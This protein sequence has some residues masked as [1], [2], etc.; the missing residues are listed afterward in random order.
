MAD[1]AEPIQ[2]HVYPPLAPG[3]PHIAVVMTLDGSVFI[4]RRAL[5]EKAGWDAIKD[6]FQEVHGQLTREHIAAAIEK[7]GHT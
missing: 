6:V 7:Y 2:A 5:S 1:E 3:Y 4:V